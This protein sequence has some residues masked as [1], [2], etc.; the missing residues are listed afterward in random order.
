MKGVLLVFH[1]Y[2]AP[3]H[4]SVVEMAAVCDCFFALVDHPPGGGGGGG[5]HSPHIMVGMCHGKVKNGGSETS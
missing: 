5:G 1:Q 3:A 2:N 4:T